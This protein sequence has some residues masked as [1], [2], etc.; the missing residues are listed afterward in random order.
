MRPVVSRDATSALFA[1]LP[2]RAAI[3]APSEEDMAALRN[4]WTSLADGSLQARRRR[5]DAGRGKTGTNLPVRESHASRNNTV[6]DL[7][8][9]NEGADIVG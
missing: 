3:R 2:P 1:T 7:G 6:G 5:R 8:D 9:D 4:D